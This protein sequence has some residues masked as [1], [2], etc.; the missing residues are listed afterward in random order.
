MKLQRLLLCFLGILLIGCSADSTDAP[1]VLKSPEETNFTSDVPLK[2]QL[3]APNRYTAYL[4]S[5]S[6]ISILDV[7]ADIVVPEVTSIDT[8]EALPRPFTDEEFQDFLCRHPMDWIHAVSGK[9]YNNTYDIQTQ[10]GITSYQVWLEAANQQEFDLLNTEDRYSVILQ[11]S[12]DSDGQLAFFM[13]SLEYEANPVHL[14]VSECLPLTEG[15]AEGCTISLEEAIALADAEVHA[16]A[17]DYEVTTYGQLPGRKF[18]QYKRYYLLRY[19]RHLNGIPVNEVYGGE[20]ATNITETTYTAALG[21]IS[22]IVRDDGIC[23]L[24]YCN[25]YDVGDIMQEN[26]E[27]LPFSQIMDIFTTIGMLSARHLELEDGVQENTYHVYKIQLGYM[28]VLQADGS[29]RY[30]PV[31]DFYAEHT[32]SG[33]GMYAHGKDFGPLYGTSMLTIDAITGTVIDRS[34]GY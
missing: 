18:P 26:C 23:Y 24:N 5:E 34:L 19:T 30:T 27:L 16:L 11:Y 31:W 12:L 20:G 6:G 13:P 17:P 15:R 9:A 2:E 33:T 3:K 29:Y 32:L 22:V 14:D 28:T 21:V 25:P 8:L 4:T 10:Y 7:D 1:A